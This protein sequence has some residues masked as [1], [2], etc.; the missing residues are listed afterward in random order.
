L[1]LDVHAINLGVGGIHV[2]EL[3]GDAIRVK[4]GDVPGSWRE[5]V[6]DRLATHAVTVQP[7]HQLDAGRHVVRLT[8]L[9][10]E[11][12][13]RSIE[14]VIPSLAGVVHADGPGT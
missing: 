12:L 3:E 4:E 8:G 5:P 6:G 11:T 10:R 7:T 9:L 13:V 2:I 14:V 1:W